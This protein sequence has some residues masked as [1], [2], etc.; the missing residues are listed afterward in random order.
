MKVLCRPLVAVYLYSAVTIPAGHG[1]V[2]V[3]EAAM[4]ALQL[5]WIA[6]VSTIQDPAGST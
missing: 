2:A 1:A 6:L 4:A 3:G 5:A